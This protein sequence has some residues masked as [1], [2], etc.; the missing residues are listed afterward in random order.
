MFSGTGIRDSVEGRYLT[1]SELGLSPGL[2][3]RLTEWLRAYEAA[4]DA[5]YRDENEV[6]RLDEEGIKISVAVR[7]ELTDAK[8]DYYSDALMTRHLV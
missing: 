6:R 5:G 1:L 2:A 7:S 3:S 4:H 8:V